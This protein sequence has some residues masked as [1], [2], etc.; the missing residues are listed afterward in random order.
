MLQSA[1]VVLRPMGHHHRLVALLRRVV[2]GAACLMGLGLMEA[3]VEAVAA[4][5]LQALILPEGLA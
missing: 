4:V 1:V 3:Q 5:T 2:V